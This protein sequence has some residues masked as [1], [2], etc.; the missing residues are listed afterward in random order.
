MWTKAYTQIFQ[1]LRLLHFHSESIFF[2]NIPNN[3]QND[4]L[5]FL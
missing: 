2:P 1:K 3:D 5:K 4:T